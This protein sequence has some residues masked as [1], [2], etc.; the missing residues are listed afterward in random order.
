M[1]AQYIEIDEYGNKTYY[2]DKEMEILHREDGPAFEHIFGN[3]EWWKNGELHREDGPAI[4][5]AD[6]S[7]WWYLNGKLSF[8]FKY[9]LNGKLHREDGPAIEW[10][11]GY[12]EWWLNGIEYSKEEFKEKMKISKKININGREFTI[13]ELNSLI[14]TAEKS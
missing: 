6:G 2:S 9:Y 5:W 12:K 14:E 8:P 13:E 1:K 3:K 11:N 10:A 7:K 4:E